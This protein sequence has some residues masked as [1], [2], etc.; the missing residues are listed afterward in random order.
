MCVCLIAHS[1]NL[2]PRFTFKTTP[3]AQ[4]SKS[5]LILLFQIKNPT[6]IFVS[7]GGCTESLIIFG[8]S[9]FSFK[10]LLEMYSLPF[11]QAGYLLGKRNPVFVHLYVVKWLHLKWLH[12]KQKKETP[13]P[14]TSIDFVVACSKDSALLQTVQ[15]SLMHS[16]GK[17]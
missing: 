6:F 12:T 4:P 17:N 3:S 2:V 13:E 5:H 9:A 8:V 14:D 7:L 16:H 10:Y 1:G 11:D 15:V